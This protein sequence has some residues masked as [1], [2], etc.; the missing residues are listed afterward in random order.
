MFKLLIL[1]ERVKGIR[2]LVISLEA[3]CRA[4]HPVAA[5]AGVGAPLDPLRATE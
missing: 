3:G 2:T 4:L 1:L 5:V